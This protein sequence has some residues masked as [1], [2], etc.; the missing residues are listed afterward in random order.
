MR[1]IWLSGMPI[2]SAD[3]EIAATR[4]LH[5]SGLSARTVER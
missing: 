1:A 5:P 4:S 2:S 3:S